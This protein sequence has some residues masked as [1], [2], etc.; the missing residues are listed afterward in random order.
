MLRKL[1]SILILQ[2]GWKQNTNYTN[3]KALKHNSIVYYTNP[4]R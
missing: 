4:K 2:F 1:N 3:P